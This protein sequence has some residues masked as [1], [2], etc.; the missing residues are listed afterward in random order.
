M[1][2]KPIQKNHLLKDAHILDVFPTIFYLL[3]LPVPD[4]IDG[5]ILR[6]S[7]K[8]RFVDQFPVKRIES[9]EFLKSKTNRKRLRRESEFDEE[10][11]K[12]LK[13]L[14]YIN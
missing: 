13:T 8:K 11:I 14:G 7:L 5:K 3:G 12:K 2:G 4:D 10:E 9:Y 6:N 1:Y